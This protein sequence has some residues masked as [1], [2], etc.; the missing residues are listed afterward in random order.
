M[1]NQEN[2]KCDE[3]VLE[4]LIEDYKLKVNYLNNH[5]SRILTRFN[6]FLSIQIALFGVLGFFLFGKSRNVDAAII[7]IILGLAT[8]VIWLAIGCQD[9]RLVMIYRGGMKLA[10]NKIYKAFKSQHCTLHGWTN[11]HYVGSKKEVL[12]NDERLLDEH[13][14]ILKKSDLSFIDR[15]LFR[16]RHKKP[17]SITGVPAIISAIL[18]IFWLVSLLMQWRKICIFDP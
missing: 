15:L 6:F 11:E 2:V 17:I 9:R 1:T 18:I 8:S 10:A 13:G 12:S 16:R 7:P 3:K 4:F 14:E 5:F